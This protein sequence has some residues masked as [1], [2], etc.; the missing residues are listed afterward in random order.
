ML[1]GR[2]GA[3]PARDQTATR[4][5][6]GNG[7]GRIYASP[8]NPPKTPN[9]NEK[10]ANKITPPVGAAYMPPAAANPTMQPNGETARA[11]NARPYN[12]VCG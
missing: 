4:T 6:R 7:T 3:C 8:T 2:G 1:R 5:Q 10:R 11:S 9:H 12:A